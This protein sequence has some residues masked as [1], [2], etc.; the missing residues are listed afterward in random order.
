MHRTDLLLLLGLAA[1]WGASYLFLQLGAGEFGPL[2]L[3]GVRAAGAALVLLPG[4]VRR[5][6][7]AALRG[8]LCPVALLGVI[9]SALP[10]VLFAYA[11]L[12]LSAGLTALFV[13]LTPL[14]TAAFGAWWGEERLTRGR[15]AGM[16]LGVAGVAWLASGKLGVKPGATGVPALAI[17]ACVVGTALYGFSTVYARRRL[18]AIAPLTVAAGSQLA[19]AAVLAP[20]AVWAWPDVVPGAG[21]WAA[22]A[23]LTVLCTALAYLVFFRLIQRVGPARTSVVTL[24]IPAFGL[25]WGVLFLGER[26]SVGLLGGCGLIL[27]GTALVTGRLRWLGRGAAVA[28]TAVAA[29]G[30]EQARRSAREAECR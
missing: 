8:H 5:E 4:V 27:F 16:A 21:A 25:G 30:L 14:A 17:A 20:A 24:L 26:V 28:R 12:T 13:A 19:A 18:R 15:F 29:G 2:A 11:S 7:R 9:N 6:A 22:A 10:Y 1:T 23:G 3:A